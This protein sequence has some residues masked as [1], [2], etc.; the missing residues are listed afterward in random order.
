M[1]A[2]RPG[3]DRYLDQPEHM[4]VL[5]CRASWRDRITAGLPKCPICRMSGRVPFVQRTPRTRGLV[6][7]RTLPPATLSAELAGD[8]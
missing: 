8:R 5:V 4:T 7:N 2:L 3:L 6:E 1:M